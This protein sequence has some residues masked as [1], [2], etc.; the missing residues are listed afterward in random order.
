MHTHWW[1][2]KK[3]ELTTTRGMNNTHKNEQKM[4]DQTRW[5]HPHINEESN[6][7]AYK[8][9]EWSKNKWT[10]IW[11]NN[12]NWMGNNN[13]WTT[14]YECTTTTIVKTKYEWTK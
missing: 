13:E 6:M 3:H 9:E 5:M 14:Q 1:M 4:N 8:N 12:Q 10:A 2:S 7:N 11:M